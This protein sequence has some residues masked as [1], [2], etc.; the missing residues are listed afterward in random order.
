M[1]HVLYHKTPVRSISFATQHDTP[2]ACIH[3]PPPQ[4]KLHLNRQNHRYHTL[5]MVK[6]RNIIWTLFFIYV[7]DKSAIHNSFYQGN[8]VYAHIWL[9]YKMYIAV[10]SNAAPS[11][12]T[13]NDFEVRLRLL[14]LIQSFQL[15]SVKC[16]SYILSTLILRT[17]IR[18]IFDS[19]LYSLLLFSR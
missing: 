12:V 3:P 15:L 2:I 7:R 9:G 17:I 18:L 5:L 16:P 11:P 1:V 13:T 6:A 14:I 19:F 8:I 4:H 10:E